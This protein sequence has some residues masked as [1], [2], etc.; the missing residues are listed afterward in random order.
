MG[1]WCYGC[2]GLYEGIFDD[3]ECKPVRWKVTPR[4]RVFLLNGRAKWLL[5][6]E[7]DR[8]GRALHSLFEA[9]PLMFQGLNMFKMDGMLY[10]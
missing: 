8:L 10:T 4:S 1:K 2:A 9:Y 6:V 3:W 7:N 5:R